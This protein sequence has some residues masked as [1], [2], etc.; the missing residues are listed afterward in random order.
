MQFAWSQQ[1]GRTINSQS[2]QRWCIIVLI[3]GNKSDLV[4]ITVASWGSSPWKSTEGRLSRDSDGVSGKSRVGATKIAGF[5]IPKD[6]PSSLMLWTFPSCIS[7]QLVF[8]EMKYFSACPS[9]NIACLLRHSAERP[10]WMPAS[11]FQEQWRQCW[12]R[13]TV[14]KSDL[15]RRRRCSKTLVVTDLK[16][17]AWYRTYPVHSPVSVGEGRRGGEA[18]AAGDRWQSVCV[19]GDR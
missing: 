7:S 9:P 2:K 6:E 13:W 5:N 4:Q 18:A 11:F 1:A 10:W 12:W 19:W 14:W 3:R 8:K 15:D 17:M 16:K